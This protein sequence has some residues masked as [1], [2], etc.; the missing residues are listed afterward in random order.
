[1]VTMESLSVFWDASLY[2]IGV[3]AILLI[4]LPFSPMTIDLVNFSRDLQVAIYLRRHVLW[5]IGGVALGAVV[6][7][8]LMCVL[9]AHGAFD[10]A[11]GKPDLLDVAWLLG[12]S[13]GMLVSP[14]T[15]WFWTVLV[16]I[17]VFALL[18]WSGYV[19]YVMSPPGRHQ[20]LTVAESDA[21]LCPDDIVLGLVVDDEAR[22]YPRDTIARPHY[23]KDTI[24]KT[25]LTIS[26]CILCNSGVA[27]KSALEG[28]ELDLKC[29]TA[30]NNNIIYYE[31]ARGNFIQQLDGKVFHGPDVGKSLVSYPVVLSTWRAWKQRHPET[32]LYHAPAVTLRDR[33]VARMLQT[34]IPISKLSRRSKPWHRIRGKLDL[35]LPAMSPIIGVEINGDACGYSLDDLRRNP[36]FSDTVGGE[37]IVVFYDIEH[38]VAAVFSCKLDT[39]LTLNFVAVDKR[40]TA[41]IARD[42]ET[43][44][45][46]S[47][48]GK[49]LDGPLSGRILAAAPH[50]NKVFWFSWAL[51]KPSTRVHATPS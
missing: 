35:R 20:I 15:G 10:S 46:W 27:F 44:T 32:K 5:T 42:R 34:L 33:L 38:D 45:L 43:D 6:L 11:G 30:Y 8:G 48:A 14:D 18:F 21:I 28:R 41:A 31:P 19:P 25:P 26:Y 50:F 51:F 2:V 22:A 13:Y 29:V 40:G 39:G 23:F 3:L 9:G 12:S 4:Y 49:G 24:G 7:R 47:V 1:M 17:A 37:P 16:T 36:A